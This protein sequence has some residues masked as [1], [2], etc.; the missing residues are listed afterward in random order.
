MRGPKKSRGLENVDRDLQKNN[1]GV[2]GKLK[3]GEDE[4]AREFSR[5]FYNSQ[6]WRKCARAYAESKMYICERCHNR[7]PH[8]DGR[9]QKWIVHHKQP[10][11]PDNIHDDR[12]A[13]GWDNLM[14]LCIECHN[15]VHSRGRS[16]GR[17]M[18]FDADGN[19]V[20][21]TE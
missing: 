12:I 15:A 19:L 16:T 20:G 3:K 11:T 9:P 6:R 18:Q 14:L 17:R 4:M 1:V 10:L 13:Y 2:P 7:F 21:F 8:R 5:A